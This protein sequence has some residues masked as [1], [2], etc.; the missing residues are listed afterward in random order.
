MNDTTIEIYNKG[1]CYYT[2][3]GGHPLNY[4][5]AFECF[6]QA[7]DLGCTDAMNYLGLMYQDGLGARK[8]PREAINWFNKA[9]AGDRNL[10]ALYNLGRSY[11]YGI[12]VEQNTEK[13]LELC[14]EVV[15]MSAG[16]TV[17]VY[18]ESCFI[19]GMILMEHKKQYDKA[20]EMFY[21]A[22]E[23]GNV[24]AAWHNLGYLACKGIV[25]THVDTIISTSGFA[26]L[27]YERGAKLGFA[28]SMDEYGRL[29]FAQGKKSEALPWIQKS[30]SM[31][32]EPAKKRLK[33]F[34]FSNNGSIFDLFRK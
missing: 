24:P 8:N 34:N 9:I 1:Y 2:G 23:Q 13:A 7:S 26:L 15:T 29:L 6:Q 14:Q 32:Y 12:G 17:S 33:L 5:K 31:G 3:E 28:P 16:N 22:A 18:P 19:V 4:Q 10:F 30:A 20:S 25:P 27:C 11:Y 21:N